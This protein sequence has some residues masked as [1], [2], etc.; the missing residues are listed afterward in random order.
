MRN[1]PDG[2]FKWIFF[3]LVCRQFCSP[4]TVKN[5][6]MRQLLSLLKPGTVIVNAFMEGRD[7]SIVEQANG[8]VDMMLASEMKQNKTTKWSEL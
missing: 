3:I 4:K 7:I 1:K 8:G 5:F 6:K 2:E